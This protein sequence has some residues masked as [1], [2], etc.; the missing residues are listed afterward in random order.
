MVVCV[1][2]CVCVCVPAYACV[3]ISVGVLIYVHPVTFAH[4][5]DALHYIFFKNDIPGINLL[6]R[7]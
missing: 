5:D 1:S 4:G 6:Q 3:S 2:L 7:T